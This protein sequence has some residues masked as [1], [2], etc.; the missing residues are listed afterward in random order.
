MSDDEILD[1]EMFGRNANLW[2][3]ICEA[4]LLDQNRWMKTR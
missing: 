2:L 3:C 4:N 1:D